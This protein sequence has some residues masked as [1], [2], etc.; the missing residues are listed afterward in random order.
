M[1]DNQHTHAW[2]IIGAGPTGLASA[3]LL[4]EAGINPAD[5]L[6]IDPEFK[7]GDF[8]QLWGEVYS[9]TS[10]KLFLEFLYDNKGFDFA[11]R[12]TPFALESL[13]KDG[14]CQLSQMAEP[15]QWVS[16]YLRTVVH[17]VEAYAKSLSLH[18]GCWN[19]ET[20]QG[21]HYAHKV[22]M[23]VGSDPKTLHYE[24]IEEISLE[25]ALK[26]SL[27]PNAVNPEDCVAVFGSSHSSMIIM[28]NLL[29][30][31]VNQ[32]INFYLTPHRYAVKMDGWILYD[33]TGLKAST[34]E[35]VREHIV[36]HPDPRIKRYISNE[37]MIA[38]HMGQCNKA[39]YPVGFKTRSLPVGNIDTT[40]YDKS[41][42]I[43]APGLFGAGI[44]YP[45]TVT[46]PFGHQELNVGLFKFMRDI[47]AAL[48]LWMQYGV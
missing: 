2:A 23:A 43:I 31:G 22:I 46:D 40:C 35:W 4:I 44:A 11:K 36:K 1:T 38:Q 41:N 29:D 13:A 21:T 25:V 15:L 12:P 48:P 7:V 6:I 27:L 28:K 33:N 3:G 9:N 42:G 47:R 17:S 39:V 32:V 34:A 5:I 10:V 45:R 18:Q 37:E 14:F 16:D 30:A 8:G 26:P 19:I 24:G 20:T